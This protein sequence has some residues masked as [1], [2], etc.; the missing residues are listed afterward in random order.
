[1]T[2]KLAAAPISLALLGLPLPAFAE[3]EAFMPLTEQVPL[4][5]ANPEKLELGELT[6]HGGVAIEPGEEDVGGLTGLEWSDGRLYAVTAGGQWMVLEPTYFRD[7]ITDVIEIERG[8]L[9]DA[10]GKS[11]EGKQEGRAAGIAQ[12]ANGEWLV[13]FGDG[14]P[15]L[16]FADLDAD[17]R[18]ATPGDIPAIPKVA[19]PAP[20]DAMGAAA[21]DADCASNGVCYIL[22]RGGSQ[23]APAAG[24][25][26][27]GPD[28]KSELLGSW[29]PPLTIAS[30]EG[31][32]V[33]E[34][35][36]K[37]YLYIAS[38]NRAQPGHK[39]TLLMKFEVSPRA[40][41]T[42]GVAP[43]VFGT[44]LVELETEL[45][46][47]TV[48]LETERA[49]ITAANF[50]RYVDDDRFDGTKCYRAMRVTGGEEPA[51]FLQ[52]GAQNHPDR[53]FPP[54]AHEPTHETGLSH[55]NG[56]L[57]MARFD[58]GTATGD[59]SIMIRDQRGLDALPDAEDPE[60][61]PGFAVFGYVVDG[62][63]V[64]HAIHA[65]PT[66][67][68]KGEGFLKGQMLATPI[69]IIEA[70]RAAPAAK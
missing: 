69:T 48:S 56:A 20:L 2:W 15:A 53:L 65:R 27:V 67:P 68:E 64:V 26:A 10:R 19:A 12:T 7:Q 42:P 1:M 36:G 16:V 33:R 32:A 22:Y 41:A 40:A 62:M 57:S 61:R 39:R 9:R 55:T 38:D 28:G 50:L 18:E 60:R 44:V 4:D 29:T 8:A 46:V 21:S 11:L 13:S 54:I 3:T 30:F 5:P 45:G 66:D 23:E 47:I 70:R 37:T 52:C 35:A 49:P 31:L 6:Y 51:G 58:P 63:E 43:K 24:I 25:L 14:Q 17:P 59:Y 34:D